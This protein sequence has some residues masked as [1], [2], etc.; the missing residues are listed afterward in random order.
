MLRTQTADHTDIRATNL[1]AVMGYLRREAPCSRAA[2]ATGT[3]LNKATVTSIVA[4]LLDRRLVRETQQTQNHV[5]RPATLLVLDGSAYATI[6]VEVGAGGLTALGCDAAGDQI[7]RWHRAG[8]GVA[9]GPARTI[10]AVAALARKA[11]ATVQASGRRILGITVAVP[12]LVDRDGT[13]VLA[14]GFG[15]RDVPFRAELESALKHPDIPVTVENDASLGV[16]AE[17]LYGPFAGTDNLVHLTGDTGV[18]AGIIVD[19]RPLQGQLGYVG[20]IGHLRLVPDGPPCGCGGHGCLEALAGL[21]AIMSRIDGLAASDA[22]LGLEQLV[23]RADAADPDVTAVLTDA[24]THLGHGVAAIVNLLNPGVVILGGAYAL[25]S[26]HLVPAIEKAMLEATIAPDA[27]GCRLA[28]ST[29][30]R[31]ATPLGAAVHA[32]SPLTRGKLPAH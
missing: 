2:I 6:G 14:A 1:A 13:I 20:E 29:F 26:D 10:A 22:Q 25:L 4:D 30:P 24:G 8:P 23:R 3:G 27:G 21:P 5:G 17:H 18:G 32:L 31:T 28:V 12:G 19:G 15:W 11:I 9:A 16:L 7:L